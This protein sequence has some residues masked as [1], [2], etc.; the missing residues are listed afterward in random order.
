M[1]EKKV[2]NGYQRIGISETHNFKTQKDI[3]TFD[4]IFP[5]KVKREKF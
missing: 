5:R 3:L 1:L 4:G 2:E